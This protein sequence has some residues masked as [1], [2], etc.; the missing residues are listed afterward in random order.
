MRFACLEAFK[1]DDWIHLTVTEDT[2]FIADRGAVIE[3][4]Q[5]CSQSIR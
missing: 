3:K 2:K 4:F 1:I 5:G